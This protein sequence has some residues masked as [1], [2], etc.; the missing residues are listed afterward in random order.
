MRLAG[1]VALVHARLDVV[2]GV[3]AAR[4][5]LKEISAWGRFLG[6][7]SVY[8]GFFEKQTSDLSAFIEFVVCIE[9][10]LTVEE[11]Q[12]RLAEHF[13]ERK[14]GIQKSPYKEL[15]LLAFDD[16]IRM[17]P[18]L[19]LPYPELHQDPLVVRCAAEA[20]GQYE[21]PIFHKNLNEISRLA[22]PTKGVEF[23]LQGKTLVDF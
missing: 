7:S 18:K 21:H 9:T 15:M 1:H 2:Q 3:E 5:I 8:K 23:F 19:T 4:A 13:S 16:L 12:G 6:I 11:T 17:S 14:K 22:P 10:M 20:W